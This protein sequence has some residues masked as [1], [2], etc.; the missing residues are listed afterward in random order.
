MKTE[1]NEY[2]I[3]GKRYKKLISFLNKKYKFATSNRIPFQTI[4]RSFFLRIFRLIFHTIK[5]LPNH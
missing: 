4:E 1:Q 5:N 2:N 3:H